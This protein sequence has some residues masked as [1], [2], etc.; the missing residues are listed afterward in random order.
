MTNKQKTHSDLHF[1]KGG[2]DAGFTSS[3]I[4]GFG[5]TDPYAVVRELMQNSMDAAKENY[6]QR[7]TIMR[8]EVISHKVE[9]IP[10]IDTYRASFEKVC[11][12]QTEKSGGK[13]PDQ[14]QRIVNTIT[15]C[16]NAGECETLYVFDNGVG[17]DIK[18]MSDLLSDG[19][20]NK[21]EG[22]TGSYGNGHLTA[23]PASDLRYVLYAGVS[24]TQGRVSSGHTILASHADEDDKAIGKDGYYVNTLKEDFF[25]QYDF[26]EDFDIPNFLS[27]KFGW[28]KNNG[29]SGSIVAIT[30]FNNFSGD[31]GFVE[32]VKQAAVCN[33]FAAFADGSLEVQIKGRS[34]AEAIINKNNIEEC[35]ELYKGVRRRTGGSRSFLAGAYAHTAFKV[36]AHGKKEIID[37]GNGN[38]TMHILESDKLA[39]YGIEEDIITRHRIDLC[40]NN[41]WVTDKLPGV[42]RGDFTNY[43]PFHCV[44]TLNAEDGDDGFLHNV[45]RE[46]EGPLHNDLRMFKKLSSPKKQIIK[47]AVYLIKRKIRE[48]TPVHNQ[49]SFRPSGFLS[50]NMDAKSSTGGNRKYA[51]G[52][53]RPITPRPSVP[54]PDT[55]NQEARIPEGGGT[56]NNSGADK[57]QRKFS[58][59]GNTVSVSLSALAVSPRKYYIVI[60]PQKDIKFAELMFMLDENIDD[61]C[62]VSSG[63]DVV[64]ISKVSCNGSIVDKEDL[65]PD[66]Q[67]AIRSIQIHDLKAGEPVKLSVDYVVPDNIPVP[68]DTP[69]PLTVTIIPRKIDDAS[70]E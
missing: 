11:K 61:S 35:L 38:L 40:R 67:G 47:D 33:F 26:P 42:N 44:I 32:I 36:I 25:N 68:K 12:S 69:V 58:R 15:E 46:A 10:G 21:A 18:R 19:S 62:D 64:V 65:L 37:T 54:K 3:G 2:D 39:N 63:S 27:S 48:L 29:G 51:G 52:I 24:S 23:L 55:S 66:R 53:F 4:S 14:A 34:G 60:V 28:I 6:Q 7:K 41:M 57:E 1:R 22:S 17:L 16:L 43:K 59:T 8:F 30:G 49:D 70:E 45:F 5:D 56:S 31:K 50:I 9:D 13:L 20:S